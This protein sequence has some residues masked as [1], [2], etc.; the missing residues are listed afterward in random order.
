M[1]KILVAGGMGSAVLAVN[2]FY[3]LLGDYP[4]SVPFY[5]WL[6]LVV[7][8]AVS[9]AF[10]GRKVDPKVGWMVFSVLIGG[11]AMVTDFI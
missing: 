5:F 7:L 9:V 3:L 6:A 11:A 4:F 1:T 10:L 2:V 8:A